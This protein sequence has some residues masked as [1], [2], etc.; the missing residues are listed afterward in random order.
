MLSGLVRLIPQFAHHRRWGGR[1]CRLYAFSVSAVEL[2]TN[3][4]QL[5]LL[6]LPDTNAAPAIG[7]AD[8]GGVH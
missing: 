2:S 5:P 1:D 3:R 4:K 6:E 8:Y 7:G